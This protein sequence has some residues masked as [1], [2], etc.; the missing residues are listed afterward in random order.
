MKNEICYLLTVLATISIGYAAFAQ[1]SHPYF[2]LEV[3]KTGFSSPVGLDHAGDGSGRLFIVEKGGRIKIIENGNTLPTPFLD[4]STKVSTGS[5]QGLLGLA[6]HP[7]YSNNGYFYVHYTN[8]SGDSR[9]SRFSRSTSNANTANPASELPV[10][11]VDQPYS[12]HNAGALRFGPDGYLYIAMGDGGDGGD[13]Q[14]RA[15][16]R[17]E[18]LGKMLRID[19]DNGSPYAI[20]PDNPFVNDPNTLSEIWAI[21][22]RNP[23]R[24]SFDRLTG[25]MWIGDVGQNAREEIHFQPAGSSGGENYGWRCY[26]GDITYNSSGCASAST[27]EEPVYVVKHLSSGANSIAGGFVYRGANLCMN[28][29]YFCAEIY[30]DTVYTIIP[31]GDGWSTNRRYF[32]GADIVS[33][34]EDEQGELY[35]VSIQ[36]NIYRITGETVTENRDPVPPGSYSSNG[37][38][39]SA[40]RITTGTVEFTAAE[41]VGLNNS[42]EVLPG[43]T[44]FVTLGCDF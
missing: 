42:F 44:F 3:Y 41:S 26:E 36:G 14:N 6:F 5:E 17:Q 12:N 40:G 9:I 33:F 4:I 23:W 2:Q 7:E 20:P 18:L 34:G 25:D 8:A 29:V 43:A 30:R 11:S 32:T 13:P 39:L 22:L 24:F 38:L 15:Q 27:Y 28:G 31:D 10:L 16:N 1:P 19:V 37:Q 35:A 21:G